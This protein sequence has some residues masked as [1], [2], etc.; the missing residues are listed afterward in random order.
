MEGKAQAFPFFF[1][2]KNGE[3]QYIPKIDSC[4]FTPFI[5]KQIDIFLWDKFQ[6]QVRLTYRMDKK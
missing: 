2:T 4:G 5:F 6:S 1:A 3:N